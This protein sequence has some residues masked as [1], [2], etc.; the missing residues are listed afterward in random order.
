[1]IRIGGRVTYVT[2]Q[3]LLRRRFVYCAAQIEASG[4]RRRIGWFSND[5]IHGGYGTNRLFNYSF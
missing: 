5:V 1:M 3:I 2:L 4:A